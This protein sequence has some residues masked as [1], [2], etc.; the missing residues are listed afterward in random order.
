MKKGE[1]LIFFSF[2]FLLNIVLLE[3]EVLSTNRYE[4]DAVLE[5]H[6]HAEYLMPDELLL[7]VSVLAAQLQGKCFFL[8]LETIVLISPQLLVYQLDLV[9]SDIALV[10]VAGLVL[11]FDSDQHDEEPFINDRVEVEIDI[12]DH[13]VLLMLVL[14]GYLKLVLLFEADL[15]VFPQ[16]LNQH[17]LHVEV[18][19]RQAS[20]FGIVGL[21]IG[22]VI[23]LPLLAL[24]C[25]LLHLGHT[26]KFAIAVV[27][28][29]GGSVGV[30]AQ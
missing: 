22:Q 13:L 12:F 3:A 1:V 9:A 4:M 18:H 16:E 17:Q 28:V 29:L 14:C 26:W 23:V 21:V 24:F 7:V 5:L 19:Y 8:V 2:A 27:V 15:V 20:Q 30:V 10:L 25:Y 6:L 11:V